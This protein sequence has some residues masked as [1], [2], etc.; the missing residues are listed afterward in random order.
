VF[1]LFVDLSESIYCNSP[2]LFPK[3][4]PNPLINESTTVWKDIYI[5][6]HTHTHTHTPSHTNF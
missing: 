6:T 5:H 4:H 2:N 3:F 1:K